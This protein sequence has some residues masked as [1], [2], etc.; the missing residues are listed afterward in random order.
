[1]ARRWTCPEC[2]AGVLAPERMHKLDPRRYC[3]VCSGKPGV[4]R[5]VERTC[6][7][8]EKR[9]GHAAAKRATKAAKA[10]A[11]RE[12]LPYAQ[13]HDLIRA[14]FNKL[15]RLPEWR[16]D[17]ERR[18]PRLD[19]IR[20]RKQ[21]YVTGHCWTE[22]GRITITVG[23][24]QSRG[25]IVKLLVHELAHAY[26]PPKEWHGD[27]FKSVEREMLNQAREAGILGGSDADGQAIDIRVAL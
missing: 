27:R 18:P 26:C 21:P 11:K 4:K 5:M 8:L 17:F 10:K 9:R 3:L 16:D 19:V 15:L 22:W 23:W 13:R 25:A 12:A 24:T 2:G 20:N 14:D 1:M 6:P 7:A